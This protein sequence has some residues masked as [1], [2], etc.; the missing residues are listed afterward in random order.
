[1]PWTY[2]KRL[3]ENFNGLLGGL[4]ATLGFVR[5]SSYPSDEFLCG[6]LADAKKEQQESTRRRDEIATRLGAAERSL[7]VLT[8]ERRELI[9]TVEW[10]RASLLQQNWKAMRGD[11]WEDYLLEVFRALGAEAKRTRQRASSDQ[12]VDLIARFDCKCFAIQAKGYGHPVGNKAIQEVFAGA[13]H[14]HCD[15]WAVVT[16]SEFTPKAKELA[17]STGC[18]LIGEEEFP[19]FVMGKIELSLPALNPELTA[20]ELATRAGPTQPFQGS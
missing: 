17:V 7:R 4:L 5:L 3:G 14:W 12:G 13:K 8:N 9:A 20:K 19:D 1:I 18:V 2:G 11:D 16:N 10:Q 15:A 6:D